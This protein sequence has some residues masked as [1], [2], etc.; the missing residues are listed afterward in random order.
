MKKYDLYLAGAVI[1]IALA[2][3]LFNVNREHGTKVNVYVDNQLVRTHNLSDTGEY[4]LG[5][6][7]L[8]IIDYTIENGK[9]DVTYAD[10]PDKLCVHQMKAGKTG[11]SI[12]CLPNKVM[13]LIEGGKDNEFDAV[14]Y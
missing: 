2:W 7:N 14:G 1:L 5:A 8:H 6:D 4:Y 11:E 10:C 13:F 9:V 12:V 3:F